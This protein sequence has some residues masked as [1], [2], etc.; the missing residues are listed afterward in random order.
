MEIIRGS[1]SFDLN[2]FL[3]R[4]LFAHLST[5]TK[6]ERPRESPVWFYWDNECIWI[7]GTSSDSFPGRIKEK[8]RC[9]IGI[10]ELDHTTG[11]VLHAGFRGQATVEPFD[12]GIA[13]RLL[14]RYLGPEEENWDPRFRNLGDSNIFVRFVPETVVVRDQSFVPSI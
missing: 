5:I 11:K 3:K 12:Q 4:P 9:A 8:P 2:E 13:K 6:D 10:V 7:I 14:S 1:N